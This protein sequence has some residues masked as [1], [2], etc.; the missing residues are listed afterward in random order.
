MLFELIDLLPAQFGNKPH[1]WS[2]MNV[3]NLGTNYFP[4]QELNYP[5]L[6]WYATCNRKGH[7][8]SFGQEWEV[9]DQG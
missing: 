2:K 7:P 3:L 5:I 1:F 9:R 4:Y 8:K 6:V